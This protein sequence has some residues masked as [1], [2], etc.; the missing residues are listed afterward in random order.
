M[1]N[2]DLKTEHMKTKETHQ[3]KTKKEATQTETL[4]RDMSRHAMIPSKES[5][6]ITFGDRITYTFFI[7]KSDVGSVHYD[8]GRGE[9]FYRGHNVRNLE[10]EKWQIDL[11]M[12]FE[13][14]L[15]QDSQYERFLYSYSQALE[16]IL[17][18]DSS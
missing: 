11:L 3:E 18:K 6:V 1:E 13:E 10:L 12:K 15:K 8:M 14:I 7:G 16:K 5:Q 4:K 2:K 9:I 17:H